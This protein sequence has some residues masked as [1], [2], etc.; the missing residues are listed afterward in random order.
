MGT[1]ACPFTCPHYTGDVDY[2]LGICPNVERASFERVITHDLI[3]PPMTEADL[4]D[5]VRAFHKVAD[6]LDALRVW[7]EAR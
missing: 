6:N 7:E 5:V 1:R 4:D 2:S 3:R